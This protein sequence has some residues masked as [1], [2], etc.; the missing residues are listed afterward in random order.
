MKIKINSVLF[1]I[2][3]IILSYVFAP[4]AAATSINPVILSETTTCQDLGYDF[5]FTPD[6]LNTGIYYY[7]NGKDRLFLTN[8]TNTSLD[9]FSEMAIDGI[10]IRGDN[11]ANGYFGYN[12]FDDTGL[13]APIDPITG[14]PTVI[15]SIELCYHTSLRVTNIYT[16]PSLDRVYNWNITKNSTTN[17]LNLPLGQNVPVDYSVIVSKNIVDNN[18]RLRGSFDVFNPSPIAV[19]LASVSSAI[20]LDLNSS[21]EQTIPL[22]CSVSF[23]YTLQ[24]GESISC[25]YE[26]SESLPTGSNRYYYINT[27]SLT[28]MVPGNTSAVLVEFNNPWNTIINEIDENI[29][30]SDSYMGV[31]GTANQSE[32]PKTFNYFLNIGPYNVCG[33]YQVLNTA[34]FTTNDSLQTNQTNNSISVAVACIINQCVYG[35]GYW[36]NHQTNWPINSLFLGSNQYTK[37]Q[38]INIFKTS[39]KDNGLTSLAHQLIAAK[40]NQANGAAIAPIKDI[41]NMA[42]NLIGSAIIPYSNVPSANVSDLVDKLDSYNNIPCDN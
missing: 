33:D 12:R 20:T 30:V 35:Q 3:S 13:S 5:S 25:N 4:K 36:K 39:V 16:V 32:S 29:I 27:V 17:S 19:I 24:T 8:I 21:P 38:L 42:D 7:E 40:L 41:I 31:L 10:I 22:V 2:L 6:S 34:S 37:D 14:I 9:Y 28:P 15:K 1:L 11:M 23:P 26:L 18:W